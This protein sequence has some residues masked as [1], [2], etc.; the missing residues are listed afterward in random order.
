MHHFLPQLFD[1]SLLKTAKG[2]RPGEKNTAAPLHK[3]QWRSLVALTITWSLDSKTRSTEQSIQQIISNQ[4]SLS[5]IWQKCPPH[6]STRLSER[7]WSYVSNEINPL[8]L[9][10]VQLVQDFSTCYTLAIY[11]KFLFLWLSTYFYQ[12]F[13]ETIVSPTTITWQLMAKIQNGDV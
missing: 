9:E 4:L 13:L 8:N 1:G 11:R 3:S 10:E 7:C 6:T 12:S 5:W 2:G